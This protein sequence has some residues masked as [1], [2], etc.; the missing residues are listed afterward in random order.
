MGIVTGILIALSTTDDLAK[1]ALAAAGYPL[2]G[3][4][5]RWG[6][7]AALVA[8]NITVWCYE[9]INKPGN[10]KLQQMHERTL[11]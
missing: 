11:A 5:Q 10:E 2:S 6:L 7:V 9:K 4:P 3:P 8:A 1:S